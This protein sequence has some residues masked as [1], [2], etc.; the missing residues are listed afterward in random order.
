MNH[1]NSHWTAA[2]INF[3]EKRVESYDSMGFA[4]EK[5]FAVRI[6]ILHLLPNILTHGPKESTDLY[7]CGT[8]EQEEEA[9]RFHRLEKLGSRCL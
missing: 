8:L 7:Q 5:V 1:Q 9:F 6:S 4:K 2:A 3:K